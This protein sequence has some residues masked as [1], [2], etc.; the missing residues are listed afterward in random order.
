[1]HIFRTPVFN[2]P[3]DGLTVGYYKA[4]AA[5]KRE[6]WAYQMLK[7]LT[8]YAFNL[9]QYHNVT[10]RQTDRQTDRNAMSVPWVVLT[11]DKML[12]TRLYLNEIKHEK[13]SYI[14][15]H[16]VSL[17]RLIRSKAESKYVAS[18]FL[19]LVISSSFFC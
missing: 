5:K 17:R 13:R 4:L 2:A 10:N 12:S 3:V 19:F 11:R 6:W 7:H 1:M 16:T 8:I 18:L 14:Y 9:I 15:E